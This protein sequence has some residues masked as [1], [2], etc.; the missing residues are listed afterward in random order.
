ML[1]GKVNPVSG[2]FLGKITFGYRDVQ[3]Y[4]ITP[5]QPLGPDGDPA[6]M[7]QKYQNALPETTINYGKE[8]E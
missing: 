1:N 5:N 2:I 3:D 4:V 6:T 8:G 7:A